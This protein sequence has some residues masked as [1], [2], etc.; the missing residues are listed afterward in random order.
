MPLI[1]ASSSP[2]RQELLRNAGIEFLLCPANV[3]ET[4]RA[5][6]RAKEYVLR[7]ASEKALAAARRAAP[8]SFVL[9]ADTVVVVEGQILGKP[10]D[11][12]DAARMLR[13]LSGKAHRVLTGVCFIVAPNRIEILRNETTWVEFRP[14]DNE[15]IESYVASG[16]PM[17]K[18]GAYGIQGLA[19]K[20]VT[21]IDGCFFNVVGLPVSVVYDALRAI[22]KRQ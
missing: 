3:D 9:G 12:R 22:E 4:R 15:E 5:G 17:D 13:Q 18:A 16:E 11:D 8:G 2:R 21:R 14:L 10:S 20:F 1:L 6:E 7:M 19:S